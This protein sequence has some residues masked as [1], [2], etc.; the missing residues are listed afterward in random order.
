MSKKVSVITCDARPG[1]RLVHTESRGLADLQRLVG[2]NIQLFPHRL[3]GDDE[4]A[5]LVAYV[6]EEGL[7]TD[8][9]QNSLAALV[10]DKLGFILSRPTWSVYGPVVFMGP[11]E[12]GLTDKQRRLLEETIKQVTPEDEEDESH[13]NTFTPLDPLDGE[14]EGKCSSSREGP[15]S[16]SYMY[17][18]S[19]MPAEKKKK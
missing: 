11:G 16:P 6:N 1:E 10:L 13:S 12:K 17:A 9:P 4:G 8:M 18:P 15:V 7:I 14:E 5:P 3:D 2:G 19:S